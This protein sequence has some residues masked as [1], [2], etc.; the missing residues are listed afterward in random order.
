MNKE[1]TLSQNLFLIKAGIIVG[2]GGLIF[3]YDIGVIAGILQQLKDNFHLNDIEIGFSVSVLYVGS[4]LGSIFGGILCDNLGRWNTIQIQNILFVIGALLSGLANNFII[5]CFGRFIIGIASAIS[6]IADVPYLNEISPPAYRGFLSSQY[7]MAISIGVLLSFTSTLFLSNYDYGWR[8]AFLIPSVIA[9]M[10]SICMYFLPESPQWLLYKDMI[11]ELQIALSSIYGK[12]FIEKL[13]LLT[14]DERDEDNSMIHQL[15][16]ELKEFLDARDKKLF[17]LQIIQEENLSRPRKISRSKSASN[18]PMNNKNIEYESINNDMLTSDTDSNCGDSS[19]YQDY[20]LHHHHHTN[21]SNDSYNSSNS[22]DKV[23]LK[24]QHGLFSDYTCAKI[25]N[26]NNHNSSNSSMFSFS[27]FSYQNLFPDDEYIILKEYRYVIL[28]II[29][30]QILA[31]ITGGNIIRNYAT[32]IF[33]NAGISQYYSLLFNLIFGIIKVISTLLSITC[34]D[35]MG[36]LSL[37]TFGIYFVTAGMLIVVISSFYSMNNNIFSLYLFL[38]GCCFVTMGFSI[39]YGPIPWVLSAEMFPTS[40]R[41]RIMSLSLIA[42]NITQL[43]INFSFLPMLDTFGVTITFIL[44]LLFNIIAYYIIKIYLVE[45]KE[46]SPNEILQNLNEKYQQNMK[47]NNKCHDYCCRFARSSSLDDHDHEITMNTLISSSSS[48]SSMPPVSSSTS[49]ATLTLSSPIS[50]T[51]LS[52]TFNSVTK[53]L[54]FS[55]L[56]IDNN[57]INDNIYDKGTYSDDHNQMTHQNKL[58]MNM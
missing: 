29:I 35:N 14:K 57:A 38:I 12:L 13:C 32:I 23:Q 45:T 34:M 50:S 52:S 4:I 28:L 39:G 17:A 41:G 22:D 53:S 24:Q 18:V 33:E 43:I 51:I 16:T 30:I 48:S 47:N 5:L 36:R 7:E 49:T 6:G 19:Q 26:N 37:F 40:I 56:T 31:Q 15:P 9:C 44:F 54:S 8:I 55:M 1:S 27:N 25:N 3:G 20:D 2:S 21:H 46:I 10:Q 42:C 58:D 11:D